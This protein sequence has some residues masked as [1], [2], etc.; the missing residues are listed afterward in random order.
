MANKITGTI[1]NVERLGTSMYGNPYFKVA[2]VTPEGDV[3]I[4]RTQIDSSINF[5]INNPEYKMKVHTFLATTAFR[6][7]GTTER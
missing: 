3:T 1:E 4:V 5:A 2:I 6:I 7:Y